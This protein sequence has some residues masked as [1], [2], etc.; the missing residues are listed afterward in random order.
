MEDDSADRRGLVATRPVAD[1]PADSGD[2]G[3]GMVTVTPRIT[4]PVERTVTSMAG[5]GPYGPA[6][7][8]R[9]H[10]GVNT[11]MAEGVSVPSGRPGAAGER[12]SGDPGRRNTGPATSGVERVVASASAPG[13]TVRHS[14]VPDT[15]ASLADRLP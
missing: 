2:R 8:G 13:D 12:T 5:A 6:R 1:T 15:V 9:H 11:A 4:V 3:A 14:N 10:R 7:N